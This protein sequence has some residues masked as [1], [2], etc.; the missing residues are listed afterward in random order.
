MFSLIFPG[1]GSQVVGMCKD[2]YENFDLVKKLFNEANEILKF[3]ISKIILEGPKDQLD[4]TE[5]TQ[6]AIFL[7]GYSIYSV[8]SKELKADTN[9]YLYFAGHSLG[10]YTA[11]ASAG[12]INFEDT[13]KILKIRGSAMQSSIPQGEGGMLAVLGSKIEII[14]KLI[15]ENKSNYE[16]FVANDNSDGQIV[17]SGKNGDLKKFSY[18][19]KK[20]AIKNIKLAVSAPFHCK[21]MAKATEI[22]KAEIEKLNITQSD[23]FII[24]NVTGKKTN[25]ISEIKDL[26][27][28]QI[29]SRVRWRESVEYMIENGTKNFIEIGPGKVLSGLIKRINKTVKVNAINTE[30]DINTFKETNG[31]QR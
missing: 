19:L 12:Y 26:L 28:K 8:M 3:P 7:V 18:D 4:L 13:I 20:Q 1:Q 16:C 6:P 31:F 15:F 14:E 21:L 17:V 2:L 5:N 9:K 27:I 30:A 22:M 25:N 10:E 24:S 11:L 23:R 29:E